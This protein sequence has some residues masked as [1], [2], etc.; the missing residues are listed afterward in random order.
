MRENCWNTQ[1]HDRTTLSLRSWG[2]VT[3]SSWNAICLT[4]T[5]RVDTVMNFHCDYADTVRTDDRS[6]SVPTDTETVRLYS[7]SPIFA[8]LQ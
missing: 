3:Y 1:Q 8:I 6:D 2:R 4:D 7:E 5:V